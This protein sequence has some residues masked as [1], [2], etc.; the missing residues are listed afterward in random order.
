MDGNR[1]IIER[2]S[3]E[4]ED[5]KIKRVGKFR[6]DK[7]SEE[8]IDATGKIVMPGLI[9]SHTHSYG[10][11]LRAT[12]LRIDPPTDLMQILQ[13]VWWPIDEAMT[14]K[15]AYAS[16]LIT[17]LK[18]IKTGTTCF[19]DTYS[20]SNSIGRSLDRISS[21]IGESGLR[22]FI[23]F[24]ATERHTRA[25]GARGMQENVRFLKRT[26]KKKR[27]RVR[28]LVSIHA[29]FTVSDEL[30]RHAR[31]VSRRFNAPITI[32]ASEGQVDPQ[33]N[34]QKYGKRAVERLHDVGILSSNTVLAHCVHVNEDELSIMK[35]TEAKVAHNPMS[36]M[37]NGVGVAPVPKML[38]K[39]ISVGLGNDGYIFDGF[40]NLRSAYLIH[41][42][43][44]RDPRIITP[45]QALEMATIN[46]AKLY[47][48]EDKL[49]SIETGKLADLIIIN[50]D[51]LPTP[52]RRKNVVEHIVNSVRGCDVETVIVDGR[53]LM[54]EKR[55][56]TL[57]EEEVVKMSKKSAEKIWKKLGAIKR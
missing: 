56:I 53:L 26:L 7:N 23:G 54:R 55:V 3:V 5:K 35:K 50:P 24:E 34:L 47:G 2:G 8:V 16:A 38:E 6:E 31:R 4:I 45:Y 44:A 11:L 17:C 46:G 51:S 12:P 25:E 14:Q 20:G 1:K 52:L 18:F 29:S 9:C 32:H 40:E 48:L 22:A 10:M 27:S 37:L 49:G 19:A 13:R 15:D 36:N 57:D 42:A 43:N 41:K 30:L 33:H 21:A 28:G 39:E